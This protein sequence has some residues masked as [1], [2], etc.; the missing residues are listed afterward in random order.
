[1]PTEL[2]HTVRLPDGKRQLMSPIHRD[3]RLGE[4][5]IGQGFETDFSSIP[6]WAAWIV[7]WSRVDVAGVYHDCLYAQGKI[8]TRREADAVW[9]DIAQSGECCANATQAW[10]CWAG[11]RLGGWVAWRRWKRVRAARRAEAAASSTNDV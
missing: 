8:C 9:R 1:M 7:R 6:F 11:L 3:T 5:V 10:V 4:I 2:L